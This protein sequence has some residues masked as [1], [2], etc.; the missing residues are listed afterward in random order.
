M[1]LNR[2]NLIIKSLKL[3]FSLI[4]LKLLLVVQSSPLSAQ[5]AQRAVIFAP[6]SNVRATPNGRIICSIKA[7][8]T[9]TI[10][11]YNNGWYETDTCGNWG[12]IH[13]S[14]IQ[15]QSNYQPRSSQV[16]CLVTNIR[17]GQLALRKAPEGEAIAGLDNNNV[18]S[19]VRGEMPW[20]YVRVI[21]G[22]NRR[23]N[24]LQGWVNANYLECAWD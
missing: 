3:S 17:T 10:Y 15:I 6:P 1:F 4:S 20:Y 9:I 19:F 18:V 16:Y 24:N 14:Q 5:Q 8:T 22:P 21:E 12:Y 2:S 13:Q 11:G 7:V 23:V